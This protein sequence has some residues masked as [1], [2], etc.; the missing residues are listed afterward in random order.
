MIIWSTMFIPIIFSVLLSLWVI[1]K[2]CWIGVGSPLGWLWISSNDAA[3]SLIAGIITSLGWTMLAFRLPSETVIYFINWSLGS[4]STIFTIPF[5]RLFKK[6][7]NI[8]R[9]PD[10]IS[11]LFFSCSFCGHPL[12]NFQGCFY[13][14]CLCSTYPLDL[15]NFGDAG[16]INIFE[17]SKFV[18]QVTA[19]VY[20]ILSCT[21]V[22]IPY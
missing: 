14:R 8:R 18:E 15:V 20:R 7:K 22:S 13:L 12:T 4:R 2:S 5:F 9:K 16:L 3:D 1:S 6:G 10:W 21:S 19:Q 11:S 17:G